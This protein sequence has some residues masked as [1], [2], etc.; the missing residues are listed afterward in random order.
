M[1][2]GG[3]P[4]LQNWCDLT[5]SGLVGSIPT[6]SRHAR[7]G[8]AFGLVVIA[9]VLSAL[10]LFANPAHA[11]IADTARVG[12]V[13]RVTQPF[14]TIRP[15]ITPRQ[16]FLRSALVPGWGQARLDRGLAGGI[17]ATM[18]FVSL[19]MVR[20]TR[21]ELGQA[22]RLGAD[23]ILVGFE[24]GDPLTG[25]PGTPVYREGPFADRVR[26]RRQQVEDWTA[27]LVFNHL[28]SGLDAFVSAHLWDLPAQV[29]VQPT[30]NGA[31]VSARI[32][33]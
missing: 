16:A 33:W 18:E 11:Q 31:V 20:Q 13:P 29:S 10:M 23:S 22:R 24:G 12:P 2:S 26:A 6:R 17:F 15:P 32:A 9:L 27:L 8:A 25:S 7:C 19:A 30:P 14:D 5:T 3:F 1:G 21:A 28:I 4:S